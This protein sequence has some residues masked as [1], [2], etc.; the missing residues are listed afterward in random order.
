[1]NDSTRASLQESLH[2]VSGFSHLP[3][4]ADARPGNRPAEPSRCTNQKFET[5]K[6]VKCVIQFVCGIKETKKRQK[7]ITSVSSG[8]KNKKTK[9][10]PTTSECV[11]SLLPPL[12]SFSTPGAKQNPCG[13]DWW[14]YWTSS[15]SISVSEA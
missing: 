10:K 8:E 2:K 7:G 11:N 4:M 5:W 12:P 1:M 14:I 3:R 6:V 9:K 15:I 13:D